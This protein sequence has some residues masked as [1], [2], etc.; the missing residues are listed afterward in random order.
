MSIIKESIKLLSKKNNKILSSRE[1]KNL[2]LPIMEQKTWHQT[3]YKITHQLKN[4]GYIVSIKKD[5][6]Y[7]KKPDEQIDESA[8]LS[9]Y[10]WTLVV[11]QSKLLHQSKW[12]IW[13]LKAL[14]LHLWN[15]DPDNNIHIYNNTKNSIERI[16]FQYDIT[17]KYYQLKD[18]SF[19]R[20]LSSYTLPY[21][22]NKKWMR[23]SCIELAILETLY[24]TPTEKIWYCN[25]LIAK[26]FKKYKKTLRFDTREHILRTQKYHTSINKLYDITR[27]IDPI[28]S[29][30]LLT[31]IKKVSYVL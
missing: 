11:S 27:K 22:I 19:N 31:I 26:T 1:L 23:I 12:Y 8:L 10:F 2:L 5:L 9:L 21:T 13:W 18:I 14:E 7:I 25:E 29:S 6:Y 24:N 30:Q 4:S 3:I 28:R 15:S 17:Y 20:F 16:M